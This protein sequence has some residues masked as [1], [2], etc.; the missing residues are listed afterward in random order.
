MSRLRVGRINALNM[1]PIYH[2]LERAATP[3]IAF[4]DGLP[5]TLNRA[6]VEGRLDVSAVS[7]IEYARN[8]DVL[9][10][11]PVASITA[12]GAVDSIQ[13]FSRVPFD[14]VRSVAVTPHSATSV[15]LLRIL[16]GPGVPFR[17][18]V[19]DARAAL[20]EVDAV[21]LIADE[22][23][24]GLRESIAP[25]HTDLAEAWRART[26]VPMVFAVWAAREDSAQAMPRQMDTLT[27][28]LVD[29]L[30]GFAQNPDEVVHTAA[31]VFPFTVDEIAAYFGRLEYGFD[32]TARTALGRFLTEAH[33]AG[34]LVTVPAL[35][36]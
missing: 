36:A 30:E 27:R 6:L 14:E 3:D 28:L 21:L 26:G 8:A 19:G 2:F 18:L 24:L 17:P 29:A 22:A 9:R 20:Q 23:L 13:L 1:Y 15:S 32:E 5:T 35:A 16:L 10:L 4:T 34:E 25:H 33:D 12:A 11:L 7:S 31:N